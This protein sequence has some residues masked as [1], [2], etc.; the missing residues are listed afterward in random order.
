MPRST[1]RYHSMPVCSAE[2]DTLLLPT[3]PRPRY[4]TRTARPWDERLAPCH[5]PALSAP[6]ARVACRWRGHPEHRPR[7]RAVADSS[8]AAAAAHRPGHDGDVGGVGEEGPEL[9]AET[10][11]LDARDAT[12]SRRKS[13]PRSTRRYHSMPVCKRASGQRPGSG[14]EPA[15]VAPNPI[16]KARAGSRIPSD[17]RSRDRDPGRAGSDGGP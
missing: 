16:W 2:R 9:G 17:H 11:A 15:D 4:A 6:P 8:R 3:T 5:S 13:M 14:W 10:H 12:R 1:R 7:H